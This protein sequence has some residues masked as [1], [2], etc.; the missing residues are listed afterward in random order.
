M[1]HEILI[2]NFMSIK[3]ELRL[4]LEASP[5]KKLPNNLISSNSDNLLKSVVIYGANASGKS[6]IIKA[7]FFL[8]NMVANSHQFNV[9]SKIPRIPFK[10]DSKYEQKPSRFEINFTY[11]KIK[12]KYGFSCDNEKI[13]DEYLF[14]SPKGR[15]ALVFKRE[16]TNKFTFTSDNTKQENIKSQTLS[17]TLYLSR[18]TQLGYDKTKKA[19]EFIMNNIVINMNP[20]W[21]G[22]TFKKIHED[23]KLKDKIVEILRKADF[24]GIED[25]KIKKERRKGKEIKIEKDGFSQRDVEDDFYEPSFSHKKKQGDKE[26]DVEFNINEESEGTQKVLAMLGSI[27]DMLEQEK[28]MFID[29]LE[30]NLH[31]EIT[32]LL[33]KLFHNKSNTKAQ[34]VFT[35]HDTNLLDNELFRKDQIYIVKR[36]PNGPTILT[37]FSEFDLRQEHD[38]ERAYLTGRVGGLPFIDETLVD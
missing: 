27:L 4:S 12:Y 35:T 29:E 25:I 20:N 8:W 26:I 2:E 22:Y 11:E 14:Y 7:V 32:K 17:N 13:I 38:F 23:P 34:L 19:Y 37:S 24:G 15:L 36:E 10:L 30:L 16:K 28:I 33:I 3:N 31:P 5:S 1:I 9:N 21:Q 18:A 6:N